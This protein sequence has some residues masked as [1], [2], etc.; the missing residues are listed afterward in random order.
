MA[1][2][3]TQALF[4][5]SLAGSVSNLDAH[6]SL[7]HRLQ[8][9]E[10]RSTIFSILRIVSRRFLPASEQSESGSTS[11][12]ND[13]AIGGI[14]ALMTDLVGDS[15]DLRDALQ[16]WLLG[17]S[18][19]G[20]GSDI[21]T[22]RAVIASISVDQ[23]KVPSQNWSIICLTTYRTSEGHIPKGTTILR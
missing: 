4:S 6:R 21:D 14:A 15:T 5:T 8:T 2:Q 19:G 9:H 17:V 3:V 1:D 18:G 10:Q 20:I 12:F 13:K 23:G 11:Q 7:L 22:R 16:D